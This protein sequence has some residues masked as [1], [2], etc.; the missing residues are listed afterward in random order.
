MTTCP[1]ACQCTNCELSRQQPTDLEKLID[2][3][4]SPKKKVAETNGNKKTEVESSSN[5]KSCDSPKTKSES[6]PKKTAENG[7]ASPALSPKSRPKT[8]SLSPRPS[9]VSKTTRISSKSPGPQQVSK[10]TRNS[11]PIPPKASKTTRNSSL[12]P[13]PPVSKAGRPRSKE[14]KASPAP[15]NPSKVRTEQSQPCQVF[16]TD[17]V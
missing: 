6:S 4:Y 17:P 2:T 5:S 1:K 12:S 10:T 7:G 15:N 8:S 13:G 9:Q 3:V 16:L 14:A 11:S